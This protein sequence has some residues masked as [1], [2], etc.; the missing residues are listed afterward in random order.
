MTKLKFVKQHPNDTDGKEVFI[1]LSVILAIRLSD[2][3]GNAEV[4]Q[5]NGVW[6]RVGMEYEKFLSL[7]EVLK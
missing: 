1:N 6:I 7:I 4:Q 2:D 5:P 3:G